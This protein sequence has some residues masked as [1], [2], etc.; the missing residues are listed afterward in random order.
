M[1]GGARKAALPPGPA[2]DRGRRGGEAASGVQ[3]SLAEHGGS[4]RGTQERGAAAAGAAGA[5]AALVAAAAGRG[6]RH[7]PLDPD[8][9][10]EVRGW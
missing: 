1:P 4:A 9:E 6:R 3:R 7:G 2:G 10:A 8:Q 5:V